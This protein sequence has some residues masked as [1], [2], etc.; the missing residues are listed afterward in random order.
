MSTV[1]DQDAQGRHFRLGAVLTMLGVLALHGMGAAGAAPDNE[2]RA[3]VPSGQTL[4]IQQ[5]ETALNAI[6]PVDRNRLTREWLHSG[7]V[8]YEVSGEGAE[9]FAGTMETGYQVGFP[10]TVG[11][12]VTFEYTTPNA[13]AWNV[14]PWRPTDGI[15][16]PDLLP[17]VT[18]S[19]D[20][21]NGPGPQEV[22]TLSVEVSGA[23]GAVAVANA[24]GTVTGAA[25]G[26][27]LRPFARLVWPDRAT[28]YTYG[29]LTTI[30]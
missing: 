15:V 13:Y 10:W 22:V 25:G 5:R 7:T 24:H 23:A 11:T 4:T 3:T 12:E 30:S 16:T 9:N 19:T 6:A 14:P 2:K 1:S 29:D 28:L 18:V 17:G 20:V 26:I 8:A 27:T 21:G